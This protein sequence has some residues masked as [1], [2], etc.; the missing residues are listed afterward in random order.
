MEKIDQ[1]NEE[2]AAFK[3]ELSQYPIRKQVHDKLMP[4]K[5]LYDN[6]VEF[7]DKYDLWMNSQ[8]GTHDPEDIETDVALYYRTI[9]KLEKVFSD[10]PAT[11]GL[12]TTVREQI[13]EFKSHM[14]I[15][16]TLGNPGMKP[17]HWE[18][19][20]EIVGFPIKVEADLTLAK[21]IDFGLDDYIAKFEAISEAAT[22]ENNLEKHLAKMK[23]EWVDMDF[24]VLV[25]RD[26][27]TY[28]LSAVDEIQVLLDDHIVKT[29]TM[30]NSPYIKPFEAEIL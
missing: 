14:P 29:Q 9:Y 13:E 16:Q 11:Q 26:T 12:A 5:K 27:G 23:S 20:S 3:F 22:K 15:I 17:R 19:I 7:L 4:Y 18:Q 8:V 21:I 24:I 28:I 25:Y 1:F 10:R 30:K 2:E 6:A